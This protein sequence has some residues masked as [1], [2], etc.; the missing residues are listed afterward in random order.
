MAPP[1]SIAQVTDIPATTTDQNIILGRPGQTV[2][3]DS[4]VIIYATRE[5][6]DVTFGITF[7]QQVV[8]PV[9]SPANIS[10]VAGSLPS[11]QDDEIA[12]GLIPAGA[13]IIVQAENVNAA[14]QEM[15]VLLKITALDDLAAG[16]KPT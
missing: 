3:E 6:V 15:R 13:D 5:S 8:L 10:T 11:V 4:E 14:A 1:Y 12:R 7:G 2:D 9:G 16:F